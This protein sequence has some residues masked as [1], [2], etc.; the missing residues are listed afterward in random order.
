MDGTGLVSHITL[1]GKAL[2]PVLGREET[3]EASPGAQPPPMARE[4]HPHQGRGADRPPGPLQP[5]LKLTMGRVN[6]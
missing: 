3:R 1:H 6:S 5:A 2:E 4:A